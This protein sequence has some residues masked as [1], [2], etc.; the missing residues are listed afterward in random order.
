MK[1]FAI[2]YLALLAIW[3]G[4]LAAP[5]VTVSGEATAILS[6]TDVSAGLAALPIVLL[7][8]LFLIAYTRWRSALLI[9]SA[10]VFALG[11]WLASAS[12][13]SQPAVS[14]AIAAQTGIADAAGQ[15]AV[16]TVANT[17]WHL[18]ALVVAILGSTFSLFFVVGSKNWRGRERR[19]ESRLGDDEPDLWS[20]TDQALN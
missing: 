17:G 3:W 9:V 6:G 8:L 19:S 13:A 4:V 18:A 16:V 5:W 11:A 20:E 2:G 12:P 15:L 14:S 1:K 10:S 7:L